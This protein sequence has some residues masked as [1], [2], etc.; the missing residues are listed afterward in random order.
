MPKIYPVTLTFTQEGKPLVGASIA[1]ISPT[2]EN[3]TWAPGGV[4]D[5]DGKAILRTR[6][7]FKGAIAGKFKIAVT[8]TESE[9]GDDGVS[10]SGVVIG[11]GTPFKLFSLVE[12]Q[13]RDIKTTP[14]EVEITPK[15]A[16]ETT[17]DVGK[18]VRLL[19]K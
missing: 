1:L 10:D 9:G 2:G 18:A 15:G 16:S 11:P 4:T 3:A 7:Q 13:Y 17:F 8:L 12:T 19:M 5:V 14:L 6:G